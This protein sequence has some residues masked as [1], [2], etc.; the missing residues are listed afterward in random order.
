[1]A[2]GGPGETFYEERAAWLGGAGTVG[3]GGANPYA[4]EEIARMAPFT[5]HGCPGA[6]F[7]LQRRPWGNKNLA[8]RQGFEPWIPGL[9]GILAFEAS[10]FNHS[11]TSPLYC[12][13]TVRHRAPTRGMF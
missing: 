8:E 13:G 11:D 4:A 10:S 6:H 5:L 7:M 1:M 3:L 12:A 2:V 9:T